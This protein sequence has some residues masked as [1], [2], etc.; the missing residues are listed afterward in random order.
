MLKNQAFPFFVIQLQQLN[1]LSGVF[2][3]CVTDSFFCFN[4]MEAGT[5]LSWGL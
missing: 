3:P 1:F 4:M 5:G 2:A